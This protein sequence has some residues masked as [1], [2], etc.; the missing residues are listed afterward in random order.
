MLFAISV[1]LANSSSSIA[2][3]SLVANFT[4]AKHDVHINVLYFIS[5]IL[6]L[7]VS[8]VCILAKQWIREY[9][10]DIV[11]SACDAARVRQIRFDSLEKWKVPELIAALPVVLLAALLLFFAGILIQL[12]H[13]SEH[14]TA[15]AVTAVVAFTALLVLF[16]TV[17]PACYGMRSSRAAFL[18]FRSPQAWMCLRFLDKLRTSIYWAFYHSFHREP[19]SFRLGVNNWTNFD[20]DFLKW[21]DRYSEITSIHR[22][23]QWVFG[24]MGGSAMVER[25]AFWSLQ[26]PE[27][28]PPDL[29]GSQEELMAYAL[30]GFEENVDTSFY[31]H[32]TRQYGWEPVDTSLG[33]YQAELLVRSLNQDLTRREP[34]EHVSLLWVFTH[35]IQHMHGCQDHS[36]T[37]LS[38]CLS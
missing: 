27:L 36:G 37:K 10:K 14:T 18:P 15:A 1:Q 9:Q 16:T 23:F 20:L 25:A 38:E 21:D 34:S 7:S 30:G 5:L 2:S 19:F 33:Q 28:H 24:I 32:S 12:W 8:A 31:H 17:A 26:K 3:E 11:G 29:I 6:A 35:N 22:V 4:P 13:V